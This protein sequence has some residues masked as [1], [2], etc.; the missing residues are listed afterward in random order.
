MAWTVFFLTLFT[1][2]APAQML[3]TRTALVTVTPSTL[4]V[5]NSTLNPSEKVDGP[6]VFLGSLNNVHVG[7][8]NV[9]T[10]PIYNLSVLPSRA[11]SHFLSASQAAAIAAAVGL[12]FSYAFI[13]GH[14]IAPPAQAY[15][16]AP[17]PA[18]YAYAPAPAPTP[19]A[20]APAPAPAPAPASPGAGHRSL[21]RLS[22]LFGNALNLLTPSANNHAAVNRDGTWVVPPPEYE[23]PPPFSPLAAGAGPP[24]RVQPP[25]YATP[26][27]VR[28]P[29]PQPPTNDAAAAL[30]APPIA[31]NDPHTNDQD[32]PFFT[33]PAPAGAADRPVAFPTPQHGPSEHTET[34]N[35]FTRL[36]ADGIDIVPFPDPGVGGRWVP[37]EVANALAVSMNEP[38]PE[39]DAALRRHD[40][41]TRDIDSDGDC[42]VAFPQ[43]GPSENT[44]TYNPFT[45]LIADGIDIVPFPDPGVGRRW[46]PGEVANALAI[47]MNGHPP[48]AVLYLRP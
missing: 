9:S 15:A 47:S 2:L 16:P 11:P 31:S 22:N 37:G 13:V 1:Y 46:V 14:D 36:I 5:H 26:R 10:H 3:H 38:P 30:Y 29:A 28:R 18:A 48:E 19:A 43:H 24:T 35:P 32:H 23:G 40:R 39:V 44:E 20:Y 45:R 27:T 21:G 41:L 8:T 4:L 34:Y 12:S 7:C 25:P 33:Q 42:P 6:S 17:A